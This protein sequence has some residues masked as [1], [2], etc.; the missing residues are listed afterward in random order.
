MSYQTVGE[1]LARGETVLLDGGVGTE[2]LRRTGRWVRNGIEDSGD[3]IVAVHRDYLDAGCEVVRTNTFQIGRQTFLDFFH[4]LEQMR[5]IGR[6]GLE[7][8]AAELQRTAV[9]YARQAAGGRRV[10]VA[11]SISP[12]HH[13]F[14]SDLAPDAETARETHAHTAASLAE[15]GVDLL[16]LE[17]FNTLREGGA[18]LAAARETGLPVWISL[19]PDGHGRTLGGEPLA[20]AAALAEGGAEAVLLNL[21]P[22]DWIDR[23]LEALAGAVAAPIG[24]YALIG[25][26]APPSWKMD[27]YPRFVRCEETSPEAYA[28]AARR[29]L[30][31][32]ARI[33]GGCCGTGPDHVRALAAMT[34]NGGRS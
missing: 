17:G 16:L 21:A 19:I 3:E 30:Q 5:A 32:G 8:R 31:A 33:V 7:N 29:W 18:A 10:A 22:I 9:G 24:A 25:R 26:Y 34:R 6:P 23:G 11:G 14:R 12:M 15:T 1:R 20:E 28:E 4:D 27:F 2:V 13:P